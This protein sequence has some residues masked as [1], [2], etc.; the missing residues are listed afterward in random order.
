MKQVI[1][2]N[3]QGR[4]VPIE[5]T[6]YE[7]LKSYIESLSRHF[8]AEEGKDEIINDIENRIGELFQERI[9]AGA[10]CIIDDDVNAI[11]KSI[12]R[13]EDFDD[14]EPSSA[15]NTQ[16]TQQNSTNANQNQSTHTTASGKKR[17]FRDENHKLVGGVC[18]GVANY[19]DV[20]I[21][22]V[23]IIFA[24]LLVIGGIGFVPYIILWIA[25][26]SSA[27]TEIGSRRKKLYRDIDEKYI[28]GVCSGISNY[29]GISVWIPRVV[30]LL[31][32][33]S[34]FGRHGWDGPFGVFDTMH[35]NFNFGTFL[36]YV[37]L[38]LVLPEAKTTAEKLEMKGEKV[39]INTIKESVV[40]EMK[41]VQH[42]VQKFGKEA[43]SI[44]SEKGKAFGTEASSV[45]RRGGSVI[46]DII[47]FCIKAFVYSIIA[48][49]GFSLLIALFGLGFGALRVFPLKDFLFTSG[50]QNAF[51][52][53]TLIFFIL[54]PIIGI[55]TWI[56]RKITKVKTGSKMLR[57]GFIAMWVV[58]WAC[59][60]FLLASISKD[61]NYTSGLNNDNVAILNPSVQALDVTNA[62]S[63]VKYTRN[64]WFDDN[65][66]FDLS[67]DDETATVRNVRVNIEKSPND[68]F[69]VTTLK[70]AC[71]RKEAY[72]DSLASL[73]NFNIQ[74][75][76]SSLILDRGVVVN[77][78]DK[79]RNQ[80]VIVTIY[81]P[82][83]KR[84]RVQNNIGWLNQIHF[85]GPGFQTS[86]DDNLDFENI[87][88]GWETGV[89][90]TMT[91]DGLYTLSGKPADSYRKN[92]MKINDDGI[93]VKTGKQRIRINDN[94]ISID[95]NNN[96]EDNNDDE[97]GTYRYDDKAPTNKFDTIKMNLKKEEKRYKDSL[98]EEKKKIDKQLEKYNNS[99][100][101]V[102]N[103][104]PSNLLMSIL[105]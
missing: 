64:N 53:G 74:Q 94:G 92:G 46:G 70:Y 23:R 80:R 56:I 14:S 104:L 43:S 41:G 103:V 45:A 76:D 2:I 97:S 61:F 65:D 20:D 49:V 4:I 82:V 3:F 95:E 86:S 101:N 25:V 48:V 42:R 105:N 67:G 69:K 5:V 15:T 73:I 17:L 32:L 71:G 81:V 100:T 39:D 44:A 26:P 60:S 47:T 36:V 57:L 96:E 28:A 55:V 66:F 77:T 83:G 54:V 12:G 62:K 72:A 31:P 88:R 78:K 35:V 29:F 21:A 90:Y 79:F 9:K 93:D 99:T 34:I 68:S 1:N 89:W 98:E 63:G 13:P 6:A 30:F 33:I 85:N 50:W 7:I 22:V 102:Y 38:W 24:I 59:V 37:I 84:I 27:T 91:K 11:I 10:T 16:N 40:E 51:A 18:S 87:E 19:F 52:W 8:D 75:K 58:G